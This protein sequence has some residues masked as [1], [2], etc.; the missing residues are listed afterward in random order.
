MK[1]TKKRRRNMT[2]FFPEGSLLHKAENESA[3]SSLAAL[4]SAMEN[5]KLLEAV[6]QKC[7]PDLT[8]RFDLGGFTAL[9]P[10]DQ[11]AVTEEDGELRDIA[12]I[13]RVGKPCVFLIDRIEYFPEPHLWLSRKKAQ[14]KC[15]TEYLDHLETG[16]I[17]PAKVT[18]LEPFGAFCDI[19]CGIPSL[20]AIDCI[21]VSRIS[22][23]SD[24]FFP[25]QEILCAIRARDERRLG[26]RGRISLTHKELLGTWQENADRFSSGQTV[27]GIVRSVESYGVFIELAPNLAGLAEFRDDVL[28]GD[29][30]S[31]Y[32]KSIIPQK[33]KIKLVLIDT[34]RA[35]APAPPEYF[36]RSGSVRDFHYGTD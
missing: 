26:T 14:E 33:M 32:I 1:K 22:H 25:G 24:R 16:D 9:M 3:L 17:L 34:F 10:K 19:G 13:T 5:G 15:L 2:T 8:L 27:M 20:I 6:A 36:L 11:V 23:P 35:P 21:S 4:E 31:V 18:H 29:G 30:C 7:E 12:V 28:P